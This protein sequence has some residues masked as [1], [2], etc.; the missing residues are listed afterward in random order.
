MK[1]FGNFLVGSAMMVMVLLGTAGLAEAQRRNERQVRDLVRTLNA[2]IDDFQYGLEHQ[3]RSSSAPGRDID[4]VQDSIRNLQTKVDDFNENLT[5]QR[6]NRDDVRGIITAAKDVDAFLA[7]HPQNRR[8][9]TNWQNVRT[10]I[11]NLASQ[12]GVT[13][14]WSTSI[15]SAPGTTRDNRGN[16]RPPVLDTRDNRGN[17][18]PPVLDTVSGRTPRTSA[19][20]TG[21]TGTYVLDS[22][23]SENTAD[24]ISSSGVA[25][26]QRQDLEA[27]L[28]APEQIAIDIRGNE[29]TL[30]SSKASPVTFVADGRDKTETVDGKTVRL[31]AT[32]RGEQLTITSVGGESDYSVTFVPADNGRTMKVTRRI[33]TTYLRESVFAESFYN[34]TEPNAGLGI[35]R[36]T[37]SGGYS[38][39]D[40]NDRGNTGASGPTIGSGRTGEFLV[41]AGTV[42]SGLLESTID[43]KVTQNYD[44]FRLTVQSPDEYRGAVIEGYLTGVGRS[45]QISGRS[46][47][48]F[49]FETITLRSG[50]RYDFAGYLQTIKDQYGKEVRVDTEGTA[51]GGSQTRET[52]KRGGIGAGLGA[53]IGAI[54]GGG[55]GAAIGAIIG[56]GAGA[57]SVIVQGRDDLQLMKGSMITIQST[58]P[59]GTTGRVSDNN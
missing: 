20:S 45:G 24:I 42:V 56:G 13:T 29:V 58:S 5:A 18:R 19:P 54:A 30:A 16:T 43:T 6:E 28:E 1:R 48:T 11:N 31:R 3:M 46:N 40:P 2:Q 59:A 41:P 21:L 52:A 37:G 7:Q 50:E 53:I 55:K 57:G 23:R 12:Y 34:K 4:D 9:D 17:T 26:T 38:T 33:T 44:R 25:A 15:S 32:I 14:D 47:V 36:N 39:S 10:T 22:G 51:K 8:I 35:D 49:N 27:R